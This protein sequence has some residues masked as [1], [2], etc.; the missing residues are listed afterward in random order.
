M[1]MNTAE[2]LLGIARFVGLFT[3]YVAALSVL[4]VARGVRA[5]YRWTVGHLLV[6]AGRSPPRVEPARE[7]LS[8]AY[9]ALDGDDG[10][11]LTRP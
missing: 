6:A 9:S 7:S 4:G 3:A 11:E 8:E 10:D 5:S 2:S 1:S